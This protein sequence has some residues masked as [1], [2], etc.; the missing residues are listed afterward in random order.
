M[1]TNI[2]M[3]VT[4]GVICTCTQALRPAGMGL[5]VPTNPDTCS[6]PLAHSR[7]GGEGPRASLSD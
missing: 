3:D 7:A 2:K 4:S 1:T 5:R 6:A